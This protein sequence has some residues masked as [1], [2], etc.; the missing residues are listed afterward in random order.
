MLS[1]PHHRTLSGSGQQYAQIG[2]KT[3]GNIAKQ[4]GPNPGSVGA[5]AISAGIAAVGI[6]LSFIFGRKGPQQKVAATKIVEDVYRQLELNLS[7]YMNGPR[8]KSNQAA[9]LAN[10]DAAW[11]WL[12]SSEGCGDPERGTQVAAAS[13]NGNAAVSGTCSSP[14]AIRLRTILS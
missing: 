10:F 12:V 6:A 4:F 5:T 7:N 13:A 1:S 14:C 11:A 3:A 9:A 8:T 2:V